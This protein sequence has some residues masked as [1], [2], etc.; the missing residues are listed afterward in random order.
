MSIVCIVVFVHER[1]R[2]S[3]FVSK[4]KIEALRWKQLKKKYYTAEIEI[5]AHLNELC[6]FLGR[7]KFKDRLNQYSVDSVL[8]FETI[9]LRC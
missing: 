2:I 8:L 5:L 4:I 1:R 7:K 6:E 9:L 3:R